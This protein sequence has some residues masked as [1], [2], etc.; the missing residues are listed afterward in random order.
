MRGGRSHR[1]QRPALLHLRYHLG[2][3]GGEGGEPAA[4]AG[5]DEQSPLGRDRRVSGEERD[6]DSDQVAADQVRG[7]RTGRDGREVLIQRHAE[8]PAQKRPQARAETDGRGRSP[9]GRT[10]Y[11]TARAVRNGLSMLTRLAGAARRARKDLMRSLAPVLLALGLLIAALGG[12]SQESRQ[13]A[14]D[15]RLRS[16]YA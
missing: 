12:C 4:E 1:P 14:A 16:I 9:H 7:E 13:R 8:P 5:D 6:G 15:E 10:L 3:E 11:R 2:G